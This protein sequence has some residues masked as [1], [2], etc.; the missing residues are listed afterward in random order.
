MVRSLLCPSVGSYFMFSFV[1]VQLK[2]TAFKF[3][4]P[5]YLWFESGAMT[6]WF[7]RSAPDV[8]SETGKAGAIFRASACSFWFAVLVSRYHFSTC[9]IM[10]CWGTNPASM[11]FLCTLL[12]IN[13]LAGI[14]FFFSFFAIGHLLRWHPCFRMFFLALG[15]SS[16]NPSQ[17]TFFLHLCAFAALHSLDRFHKLAHHGL[18]RRNCVNIDGSSRIYQLLYFKVL[19]LAL[20]GWATPIYLT[21]SLCLPDALAT[22]FHSLKQCKCSC[23]ILLSAANHSTEAV[24]QLLWDFGFT[25]NPAKLLIWKPLICGS[26]REKAVVHKCGA[27]I[28]GSK[29]P[30]AATCFVVHPPLI[31][32]A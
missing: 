1:Q 13:W 11:L 16:Y 30:L 32:N 5:S 12:L 27:K 4:A 7:V 10:K 18:F 19:I 21:I 29:F 17:A 22:C 15:V 26:F 6:L 28:S 20:C 23:C 25:E 31:R 14:V 24:K 8:L 9:S 3:Q 2:V